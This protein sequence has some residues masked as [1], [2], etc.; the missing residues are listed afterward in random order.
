LIGCD[1]TQ[2]DRFTIDLLTNDEVIDVNQDELGK[3]ATRAWKEGEL[4][5]WS[6]PLHDGSIA[7]GLFNRGYEPAD[8]TARWSDLQLTGS[9]HVRD[10][11]QKRDAGEYDDAYKATIPGHGSMLI[12]VQPPQGR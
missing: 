2:M 6:R 10:L 8:V 4:E 3:A 5:V 12:K 9:Q 1:M 11:W 7:V